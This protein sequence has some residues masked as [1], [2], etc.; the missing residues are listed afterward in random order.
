VR[1]SLAK[2]SGR[3][4]HAAFAGGLWPEV[5]VD[6]LLAFESTSGPHSIKDN[7]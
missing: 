6:I 7:R 1:S 4:I 3:R 2:I 5:W